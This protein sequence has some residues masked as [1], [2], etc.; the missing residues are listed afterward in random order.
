MLISLRLS[1]A[2]RKRVIPEGWADSDAVSSFEPVFTS[3]LLFAGTRSLDTNS[4]GEL[5]LVGGSDGLAGVYSIPQRKL[6]ASLNADDGAIVDVVWAGAHPVTATVNGV[7]RVWN[8]NGSDSTS[9][10]AHS[11]G[12]KAVASHP[13]GDILGSV[14]EDKSWAIYDLETTKAVVQV[15]GESGIYFSSFSRPILA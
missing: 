7:L 4:T 13:R 3:E 5:A 14:G 6:L 9:T 12:L 2:R 10:S 11:G 8:E 1:A 15:Y